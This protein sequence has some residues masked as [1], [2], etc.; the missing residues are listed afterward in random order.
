MKSDN[1]RKDSDG[2]ENSDETLNAWN[3]Y[4]QSFVDNPLFGL[5][6]IES[7]P[8]LPHLGHFHTHTLL[9]GKLERGIILSSSVEGQINICSVI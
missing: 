2:K 4:H 9:N 8:S 3:Y 5:A 6:G 1:K 7:F